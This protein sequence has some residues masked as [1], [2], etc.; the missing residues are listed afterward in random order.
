MVQWKQADPDISAMILH[1]TYTLH[2][3]IELAGAVR[4]LVYHMLIEESQL[5]SESTTMFAAA[6]DALSYGMGDIN[7]DYAAALIA[8]EKLQDPAVTAI[9]RVVNEEVEESLGSIPSFGINQAVST[10]FASALPDKAAAL[11]KGQARV[12]YFGELV[13]VFKAGV[14]ETP[15]GWW[16][17]DPAKTDF[18]QASRAIA[19]RATRMAIA[20]CGNVFAVAA[21]A[22]AVMDKHILDR[23]QIF[24]RRDVPNMCRE[25]STAISEAGGSQ[26]WAREIPAA[27]LDGIS[28]YPNDDI[29][30]SGEAAVRA[31]RFAHY[32]APMAAARAA[33]YTSHSIVAGCA[34]TSA[35]D[36]D[37]FESA[38]NKVFDA[39]AGVDHMIHYVFKHYNP[40][41]WKSPPSDDAVDDVWEFFLHASGMT[42]SAW[43]AM[44]QKVDYRT[45]ATAADNAPIISAYARTHDAA[46]N[47][48][49]KAVKTQGA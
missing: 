42:V 13:G 45:V 14:A 37:R 29:G 20:D 22:Y 9:T 38:Y 46:M 6:A 8:A 17:N 39:A 16:L 49:T 24:L 40:Y 28:M 18:E 36:Q 26:E 12:D 15:R 25:I 32:W 34:W 43:A 41:S 47:V 1:M 19:L 23:P 10:A 4:D 5:V 2:W 30:A 21:A 31:I 3:S 35:S 44:A 11:A 33:F 27:M 48:A 7:G